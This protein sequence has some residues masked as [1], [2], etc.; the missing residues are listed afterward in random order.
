MKK[1]MI[2]AAAA[3]TLGACDDMTAKLVK[4]N[5]EGHLFEIAMN[6]DGAKAKVSVDRRFIVDV[7]RTQSAS[8]AMYL[9]EVLWGEVSD[10]TYIWQLMLVNKGEEWM[11]VIDTGYDLKC[12]VV[13]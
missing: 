8:G 7:E 11:A 2:A 9:G 4:L 6:A 5:C 10:L 3:L 1:Y 12:S 13:G